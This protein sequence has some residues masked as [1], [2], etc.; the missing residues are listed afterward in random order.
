MQGTQKLR[1]KPR[2]LHLRKEKRIRKTRDNDNGKNAVK[3]I[4]IA[5][6]LATREKVKA[7]N[8]FLVFLLRQNISGIY[9]W[10]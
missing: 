3:L 6:L 9:C 7:G 10:S 2:D 1:E 5:S 4:G 8:I